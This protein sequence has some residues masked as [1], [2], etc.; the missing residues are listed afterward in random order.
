MV[1]LITIFWKKTEHGGEIAKKKRK[2]LRGHLGLPE[3]AMVSLVPN[4]KDF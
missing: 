2:I 4:K 3:K 1:A